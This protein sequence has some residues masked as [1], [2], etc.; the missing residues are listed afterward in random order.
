ML[1]YRI[2]FPLCLTSL[3]CFTSSWADNPPVADFEVIGNKELSISLL[4]NSVDHDGDALKFRWYFGDDATSTALNPKHTYSKAGTYKVTLKASDG[5]T[6]VKAVKKVTV[7]SSPISD[8]EVI[9]KNG[10]TIGFAS[11]S[12]DPDGDNLKYL[13]S[14]GDG[15]TSSE[16]DPVH[17]F[18]A[19]GIYRI[20]LKVSDGRTTVKSVK[21]MEVVPN[22]APVADF[23]VTDN[24]ALRVSLKD[25]SSDPDGDKLKFKWNFGDGTTSKEQDPVHLYARE[26]TYRITLKVSDGILTK[27]ISKD[28]TVAANMAPVAGFEVAGNRDLKI[29]LQD[30]SVDPEGD[31]LKYKWSFGDG[32]TSSEQNPEHTYTSAGTYTVSLKVSDGSLTNTFKK[33][34]KVNSVP[35][36]DFSVAS[37]TGLR[38][39]FESAA[40]DPDGDTLKYKWNFGDGT[41][42]AER[43]PEHTYADAGVYDVSLTVSDGTDKRK[44]TRT[45]RIYRNVGFALSGQVVGYLEHAKVCLDLDGDSKCSDIEPLSE[46]DG[47][48][49]FSF[50]SS[51]NGDL[52][53]GSSYECIFDNACQTL[54]PL[55]VIAY[56]TPETL[57]HTLGKM[58]RL[59]NGVVMSSTVFVSQVKEPTDG[60]SRFRSEEFAII[61]PFTT[62]TDYSVRNCEVT[63]EIY[64][65]ALSETAERFG[66]QLDTAVSD[67]NYPADSATE[68]EL[69]T[70]V[71]AEMLARTGILPNSLS[72][73]EDIWRSEFTVDELLE[74]RTEALRE[75]ISYVLAKTAGLDNGGR[76]DAIDSFSSDAKYSFV[77]IAA[78]EADEY[79]CGLNKTGNVYCWG[80]N[81]AG[82]L[83]DPDVYPKDRYGMPV[84][85]GA[86][87]DDNFSANPVKVRVDNDAYLSNVVDV[88]AANG[89]VCAVTYD[90]ALYCWGSNHYGQI[91][92]GVIDSDHDKVFYATR[93][94]RGQQETEGDYLSNIVSV[95]LTHN[96]SCALTRNGEVYCFGENSV[97][98]LGDSYPD[99]E[100]KNVWTQYSQEG[101]DVGELLSAVPYPVRVRFPDTV[102]RVNELAGGLWTYC[103]LVEKLD[104]DTHNLYCWGDDIGGLVSHSL[105]QY[106]DEYMEKYASVLRT[107]DFLELADS[108]GTKNERWHFWDMEGEWHPLFGRGV[109]L[110]KSASRS[111]GTSRHHFTV[112]NLQPDNIE[113][114]L[115]EDVQDVKSW[116]AVD[117]VDQNARNELEECG[118]YDTYSD[119]YLS[120]NIDVTVCYTDDIGDS[121]CSQYG[122]WDRN[123]LKEILMRLTGRGYTVSSLKVEFDY[124]K[125]IYQTLELTNVTK[126][127]IGNFDRSLVVEKDGDSKF[128][129]IYN[130]LD[131]NVRIFEGLNTGTY[132]QKIVKVELNTEH[133]LAFSVSEIGDLYVSSFKPIDTRYDQKYFGMLGI[134]YYDTTDFNASTPHRPVAKD[135]IGRFFLSSVV[136]LSVGKRSVCA[137][138][139]VMD[140]VGIPTPFRDLYCWGSSTFGQLGFDNGYGGF[141]FEDAFGEWR[142]YHTSDGNK[143]FNYEFRIEYNPK[144]VI[145][146]EE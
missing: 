31:R 72:R 80:N 34:I 85:N 26:G 129:R 109:T 145:F 70:L 67:Y 143:Y 56:T 96:A 73:M 15:Q 28:V 91:G 24:K 142:G 64:R 118:T 121:D 125:G 113:E 17:V 101:I 20:T 21:S 32:T 76:A 146:E 100:I 141:N 65:N 132:G 112:E 63:K 107:R 123:E 105:M 74:K 126:V 69:R 30:S 115:P 133:A 90:G 79:K 62:L 8:F 82:N 23:V 40:T 77:K 59:D 12:S 137:L 92:I 135:G 37:R 144:R 95:T 128:C 108:S 50:D 116:K 102:G 83:G 103:A 66:L 22:R 2:A 11:R 124:E 55:R 44:S 87:V 29:N 117:Q 5:R 110:V 57:K 61:N 6:T 25:I 13:W 120:Y 131:S 49:M 52:L 114:S 111:V 130:Y 53:Q 16:K 75:D 140:D 33:K 68:D 42:S 1:N 98:Q 39:R 36:S 9:S 139:T 134:G 136:D 4:N 47:N 81:F 41:T 93:V 78:H 127:A 119:C 3:V 106:E 122:I 104:G 60:T 84:K 97:K 71:T 94:V 88:Y 18:A 19:N 45:V 48:G 14:F 38:V 7:N 35:L 89:H 86:A 54:L 43:D 46:T 27:S 99:D 138:T 10:L 51:V 58:G